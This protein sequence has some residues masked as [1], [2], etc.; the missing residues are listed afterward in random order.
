M[1]QEKRRGDGTRRD[2]TRQR[3]TEQEGTREEKRRGDGTRGGKRRKE[4]SCYT[5][6][7]TDE[8]SFRIH[9]SRGHFTRRQLTQRALNARVHSSPF[10]K[11]GAG[12]GA[13]VIAATP[14]PPRDGPA[15]AQIPLCFMRFRAPGAPKV[16]VWLRFYS[17]NCSHTEVLEGS[18]RQ[19]HV[20]YKGFS[21]IE[22]TKPRKNKAKCLLRSL[23]GGS[24]GPPWGSP[25]DTWAPRSFPGV[26]QGSP[27]ES[28]RGSRRAQERPRSGPGT[29]TERPGAAQSDPGAT[30]GPRKPP[31]RAQ[32]GFPEVPRGSLQRL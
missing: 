29:P 27:E 24:P 16:L 14:G 10:K 26:P 17:G 5:I 32:M 21:R 30:Q 18:R 8:K 20:S 31:R 13:L 3:A 2:K 19:N 9:G 6:P 15:G 23:S 11:R 28:R 25:G 7:H 22:P 4:R 12:P 1:G